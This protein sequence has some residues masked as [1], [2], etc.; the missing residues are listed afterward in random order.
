M[1]ERD[2]RNVLEPQAPGGEQPPVT[3]EHAALPV[4]QNG[5]VEAEGRDAVGD[6]R[7]LASRVYA[8]VSGIGRERVR[9]QPADMK[10]RGR[11]IAMSLESCPL[12][13]PGRLT[14]PRSAKPRILSASPQSLKNK[15][16]TN[17]I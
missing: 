14:K 7:D 16:R 13:V 15:R 1:I 12:S 6:A 11:L 9:G 10:P 8:R 2:G 4:D 3:R 17:N 5:R